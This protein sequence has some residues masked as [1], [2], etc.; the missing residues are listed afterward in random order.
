LF[1]PTACCRHEVIRTISVALLPLLP[2]NSPGRHGSEEYSEWVTCGSTSLNSSFVE[3]GQF[4][5]K[6]SSGNQTWTH[7]LVTAHAFHFFHRTTQAGS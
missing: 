6:I 7:E 2:E 3:I 1:F 5:T 4:V